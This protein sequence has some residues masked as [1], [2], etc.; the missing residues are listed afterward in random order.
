MIHT[1]LSDD[2]EH[3]RELYGHMGE[4][5][6]ERS[7]VLDA[8]LVTEAMLT[9]MIQT[10]LLRPEK[11]LNDATYRSKLNLAT[12]MG[13]I[14]D[15]EHAILSVLNSAR[16][17]VAHVLD[18]PSEKWENWK[19]E[20]ERLTVKKRERAEAR[21]DLAAILKDVV[22]LL[23]G[24]WLYAHYHH[25]RSQL[26]LQHTD[27]WLKIMSR[28]LERRPKLRKAALNFPDE[29]VQGAIEEV[30]VELAEQLRDSRR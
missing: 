19:V 18:P 7:L 23:T 20:L 16:N 5:N 30:D 6:R 24:P 4:P 27:R 11:W 15:E 26:R 28:K 25:K 22:C 13:L 10:S 3:L 14:A 9:G 17:A 29:A 8:H 12:A 21:K 2:F 1:V